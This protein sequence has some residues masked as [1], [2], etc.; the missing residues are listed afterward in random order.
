MAELPEIYLIS[1]QMQVELVDKT[2]SGIE[3]LQPKCLNIPPE[4]FSIALSGAQIKNV[5]Y[6][7]KW[8]FVNTTRGWLLLCLGMGGEILLVDRTRMPEK[9]RVIFDLANSSCLVVNFWWFGYTH[10]TAQLVDHKMTSGLGP[11]A[12]DLDTTGLRS[13][14]M[15]R[16]G[17][18]KS[19][20]LDQDRI[21]GIGNFYVHDILFKAHLHPMR[22]IQTLTENEVDGLST[23]IH[24]R[25]ELA[26]QKGGFAYE[27]DLFGQKGHFGMDDLLIGYKEN[28]P[29]P[30][31]GTVIVKIKTGS[32]SSFICSQCQPFVSS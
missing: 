15:N 13:L 10:F 23:A 7:G 3:I 4:D 32:T 30:V 6:R 2:I 18:L 12:I 20:L 5:S 26:I 8:V 21:A 31:C 19:F 11:N 9:R 28:Q 14:F 1:Q 24:D 27:Q 29:C 16:R 25:L 22:T 17:A